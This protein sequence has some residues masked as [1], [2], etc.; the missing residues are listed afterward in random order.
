MPLTD[1][2]PDF[3][4]LRESV[5]ARTTVAPASVLIALLS[6]CIFIPFFKLHGVS[7]ASLL[8]W[9]LP[10]LALLVLRAILSRRVSSRLDAL[11]APQ[12]QRAD[13]LLRISSVANQV[14]MGLGIWI[15]QS[16]APDS[17]VIPLCMTLIAI[18]WCNGVLANLFSDFRSFLLSIPA[19]MGENAAFWF[20]H[21]HAGI[22]IGMAILLST[23]FWV[24]LARRSARIFRESVLMRFEK[25][26]LLAVVEAE[27]ERTQQALRDLQAANE[28][29]AFFMAAASHDIKQPLH[30]LGLLT[31]TL[32]MSEL[33]AS[34]VP[35]LER[36]RESIATMATHFDAI[37]D[38]GRFE[39]GQF[40]LAVRRIPL[41]NVAA[42]IDAEI[43]PLCAEKS[44]AW[45]LDFDDA[46]VSTD[47]ELLLRVLRNLLVNAVSCTDRGRVRCAAKVRG[48]FIDFTVLDTGCGIAPEHQEVIFRQFVRLPS[49]AQRSMGAGLGLSIVDKINQALNLGLQMSSAPGQGTRFCFRLPVAAPA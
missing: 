38:F 12:M 23:V 34:A 7:N 15:V 13:T 16:P 29:K 47:E 19:M 35:I 26:Q 8:W 40:E 4:V 37:M 41:R 30:A 44:L 18:T 31:E 36:Q 48:M 39:G 20:T 42:R 3:I 11:D 28:S 6:I 22:N 10:I 27:R 33:P 21:G 46:W 17:I 14:V 43:A 25:D 24:L 5:R 49:H 2:Q 45:E 32:L 1:S 9:A